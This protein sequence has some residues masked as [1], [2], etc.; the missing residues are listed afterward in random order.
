VGAAASVLARSVDYAR[1]RQQFGRQ[2]GSFQAVKHRLA[3]MHCRVELARSAVTW[4]AGEPQAAELATRHAVELCLRVA[5]DGIQVQGGIGYTW[6]STTHRFLRQ[7]IS[8]RSLVVAASAGMS[9]P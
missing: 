5:E 3:D 4:A 8:L 2:I 1:Q 9:P 7:I 6:E